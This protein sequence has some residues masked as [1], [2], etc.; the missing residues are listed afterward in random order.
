MT[1]TTEV[2]TNIRVTA[3][4]LLET[5][6][7]D[8]TLSC[9]VTFALVMLCLWKTAERSEMTVTTVVTV[10]TRRKIA[11]RQVAYR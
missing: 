3:I 4:S 8:W 1:K 5:L 11:G 7:A 10:M 2:P 6:T 9:L